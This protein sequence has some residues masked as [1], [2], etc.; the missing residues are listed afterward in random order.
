MR[1]DSSTLSLQARGGTHRTLLARAET[2]AMM[3]GA[4]SA[5]MPEFI[6]MLTHHDRTVDNA[7][8][9]C[10]HVR[11]LGLRY[12][13]FKDIGLPYEQDN[14]FK[15]D[16]AQAECAYMLTDRQRYIGFKD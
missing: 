9:I 3:K 14:I 16:I 12:I 2:S 10:Q 6:L 15:A 5:P 4:T 11:T 7:L 8:S 13:G 1:Q